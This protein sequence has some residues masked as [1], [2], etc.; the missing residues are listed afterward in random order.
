[1][2][3]PTLSGE[4]ANR[5]MDDA[6]LVSP[7]LE[8][9]RDIFQ[10]TYDRDTYMCEYGRWA[11]TGEIDLYDNKVAIFSYAQDNPV[12][13]IIEDDTIADMMQKLFDYMASTSK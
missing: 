12:A 11:N 9:Y 13:L 1:M 8:L 5:L 2:H 7:E 3:A 10:H 6:I 4:V